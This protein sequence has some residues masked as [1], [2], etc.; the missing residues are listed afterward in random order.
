MSRPLRV[1]VQPLREGEVALATG[2]ARYVTR[3]HRLR[4]GATF[5]AF[6]PELG[7][8]A[9][10]KLL[11]TRGRRVR[12]V[13]SRLRPARLRSPFR[14]TLACAM[15]KGDKPDRVVRDATALGVS[16]LILAVTERSVVRPGERGRSRRERWRKIAVE[17]ARQCGRGDVPLIDGPVSFRDAL[18]Q[19]ADRP[20]L[21]LCLVAGA[22]LSVRQ[23]L[24]GHDPETGITLLVG[25]EG[26]FADGELAEAE[27]AGFEATSIGPFVLRTETAVT[28]ALGA[29]VGWLG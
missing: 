23:A 7:Q 21:K 6:D 17:A 2:A 9:D 19:L 14:V 22:E 13:L 12:V 27:E 4:A 24:A 28:A 1:C 26:G 11:P 10:A 20:G 29:V 5:V 25:P 16:E 15:G 18:A 8:E 3:V